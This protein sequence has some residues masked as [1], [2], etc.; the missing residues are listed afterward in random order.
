MQRNHSACV[1]TLIGLFRFYLSGKIRVARPRQTTDRE[2]CI[3]YIY[4]DN[5][6]KEIENNKNRAIPLSVPDNRTST[7]KNGTDSDFILRPIAFA[8]FV[9]SLTAEEWG[10][11]HWSAAINIYGRVALECSGCGFLPRNARVTSG[12]RCLPD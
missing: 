3:S 1:S 11:M 6:N 10:I 7:C 8:F 12:F 2:E 9:L 4:T 5:R